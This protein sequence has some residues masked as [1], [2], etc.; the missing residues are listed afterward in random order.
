MNWLKEFW[1]YYNT[2]KEPYRFLFAIGMIMPFILGI[3]LCNLG[4]FTLG[5]IGI[6][7][8]TFLVLSKVLLK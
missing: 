2:I 4:Y 7:F 5:I 1:T 8:T 6:L 3:N